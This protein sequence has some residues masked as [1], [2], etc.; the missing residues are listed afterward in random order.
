MS[1]TDEIKQKADIV[2]LIG[3][4]V[5]LTK[6]G[7]TMR[8]PCPFHSEKKPSFFVYPEQQTWH[9]FGACNTGGDI[10]SFVMKKESLEFGDALRLLA[11]RYGVIIPSPSRS[12]SEDQAREKIFQLNL[13]VAQYYHNIFLSSPAAEK[14]RRYLEGRGLNAKSITDFQIG[15]SLPGWESLKTYLLERGHSE[16]DLLEAGLVIRSEESNR[17]HDRFR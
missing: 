17:T 2:E 14:A 3:S 4:Y 11:D 6:S 12:T 9:C 1:V 16:T 5:Q 8:A 7:R 13:A 10:F 15:Y